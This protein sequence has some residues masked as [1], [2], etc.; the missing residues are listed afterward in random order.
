MSG[1]QELVGWQSDSGGRDTLDIIENCLLTIFACTW[2]IQHLNVPRLGASFLEKLRTKAQWAVCTMFFP[3]FILAHAILELVMAGN[4]LLLLSER[5]PVN[6]PR[7][8]HYIWRSVEKKAHDLENGQQVPS[9]FDWTLTHIYF[10]NMG[11]FYLT[12][13][14]VS[15]NKLKS[16]KDWKGNSAQGTN[17]EQN[18]PQLQEPIGLLTA[19]HFA[20]FSKDFKPPNLSEEDLTDKSKTDYFTKGIAVLQISQLFLSLIVRRIRQFAYSQLETATLVFAVCGVTTYICYWYKPQDVGTPIA[21]RGKSGFKF[22]TN[23]QHRT[24]DTLSGVLTNRHKSDGNALDRIPNDNIPK[25]RRIAPHYVLIMLAVLTA[26]FGSIHAIAWDFEFPTQ[27]EKILWRTAT[28]VSTLVPP[29]ALLAIPLCQVTIQ[30]GNSN[31]FILTCLSV[32]REYSWQ[33][34]DD[35]SVRDAM[36]RLSEYYDGPGRQEVHYKKIFSPRDSNPDSGSLGDELLKFIEKNAVPQGDTSS[37]RRE[38]FLR[39][40]RGLVDILNEKTLSEKL[41]NEARLDLY[42]RRVWPFGIFV[43]QVIIYVSSAFY[44]IAR[45]S[46]IAVAFSSLRSMPESVYTTTWTGVI[47]SWI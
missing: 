16:E 42:P 8:F 45:L 22:P 31:D 26:G 37:N 9:K 13:E 44:C 41:Y 20:E 47:P 28:L 2:S 12:G 38:L 14:D 19:Y 5:Q 10:A 27:V 40:F 17:Q 33:L 29:L 25:Y 7:W 24:F 1:N 39:Q 21:V 35:K 46:I 11:G 32:M 4:S 34:K 36:R 18:T 15:D 23:Y 43:N 3:E 6:P 30:W